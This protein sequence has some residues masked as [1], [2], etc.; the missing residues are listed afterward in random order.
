[1][2]LCN[3]S[4]LKGRCSV[5]L[6]GP[7]IIYSIARKD[8]NKLIPLV[9]VEKDLKSDSVSDLSSTLYFPQIIKSKF[10][11]KVHQCGFIGMNEDRTAKV[12]YLM[13][14]CSSK[15][16]YVFVRQRNT[17]EDHAYFRV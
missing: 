14:K 5:I 7:S 2:L 9:L 16:L 17:E 12:Y 6:N 1:M 10:V 8:V 15:N 13:D 3:Y 11:V 4:L